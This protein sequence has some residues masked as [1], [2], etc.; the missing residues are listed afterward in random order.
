MNRNLRHELQ[1]WALLVGSIGAMI[2]M[3]A[4]ATSRRRR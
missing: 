2:L 4:V 1:S 3:G